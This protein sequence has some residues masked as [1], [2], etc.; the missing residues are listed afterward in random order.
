MV[1][2]PLGA[3]SG[4]LSRSQLISINPNVVAISI[5]ANTPALQNIP[6]VN[7]ALHAEPLLN[8]VF[9]IKSPSYPI[10]SKRQGALPS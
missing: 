9:F 3:S 6:V 1:K 10:Y 8:F 7:M 2:L 5:A 4:S